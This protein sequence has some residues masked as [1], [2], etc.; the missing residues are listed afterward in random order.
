MISSITYFCEVN[1]IPVNILLVDDSNVFLETASKFLASSGWINILGLASSAEE[2]FEKVEEL[3]PD[4]VLMDLAM[5]GIG[6]VQA[7]RYL[8]RNINSPKILVLSIYNDPGYSE[9][10]KTAG[11]DGF[12]SKSEFGAKI[13]SEINLLFNNSLAEA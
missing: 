13:L 5:P 8:K 7:T 12:L 11:A 4:L 6:G 2:S 9:L 3:N 1:I 10:V